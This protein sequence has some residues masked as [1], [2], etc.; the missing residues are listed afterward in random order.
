MKEIK[1]WF[2][3]KGYT[4]IN[5]IG[6]GSFGKI[7]SM[8]KSDEQTICAKVEPLRPFERSYL[9]HEAYVMKYIWNYLDKHQ[10]DQ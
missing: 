9:I 7:Y 5:E 6:S 1:Q 10:E 3:L 8:V 4:F 2:A